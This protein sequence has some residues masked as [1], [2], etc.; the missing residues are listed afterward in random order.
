MIKRIIVDVDNTVVD[1]A[2]EKGGWID[3]MKERCTSFKEHALNEDIANE[4]ADY[5]AANYFR[6]KEGVNPYDFFEEKG[7]YDEFQPFYNAVAVLRLL[8]EKYG[9]KIIFLTAGGSIPSKTRFLKKYFPFMTTLITCQ[10][11]EEVV[12]PNDILI[13]DRLDHLVACDDAVFKILFRTPWRQSEGY[14]LVADDT[15]NL[16][17]SDEWEDIYDLIETKLTEEAK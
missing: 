3:Y 4:L 7:L 1:T 16:F 15:K 11:K 17:Y 10:D 12:L 13:D 6:F 9:C 14:Q 5:N 2:F 8:K